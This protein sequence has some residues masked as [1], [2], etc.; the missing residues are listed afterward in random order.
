MNILMVTNT[1][2]PLLG[3]LEKS[4]EIFTGGYR[5]RGHR[6]IIV[7]PEFENSVTEEDLIR[8]PAIQ[9]FKGTDFSVQLPAPGVLSEALGSFRPDI[10]HAHHPFLLGDSA[11]RLSYK[12]NAPLVFTHHTLYEQNTHYVGDSEALKRFVAQLAT[13]YANLADCAFAPSDSVKDLM[14]ERGVDS[15]IEVV[16]TGIDVRRFTKGNPSAIR[17]KYGVPANAFVVGHLGRL[18]PEKNPEFMAQGVLR[19]LL[20]KPDAYFLVVGKGPSE[21]EI[22]TFFENAGVGDRLRFTGPLS[23]QELVDG[24]HAMDVFAF[25]SHSETQGLV[26]AEAMASGVP[27]VALDAPGAREVVWDKINGRLLY[28]NSEEE[29][30]L[31][32]EWIAALSGAALEK[33]RAACLSTAADFSKEKSIARALEIY[34]ELTAAKGFVRRTGENTPWENT[35]R[36]LQADWQLAKNLTR[37]TT[38]A[39]LPT[40]AE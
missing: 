32:L 12:Y 20:K 39:L 2:K 6:V 8:V 17:E 28:K 4:I 31:A 13:G 29:F 5:R 38:E 19:F 40:T 37:A 18:A 30:A 26:L 11:V 10:I 27:V 34:A 14:K 33:V 7:A 9:H 25:A 36:L 3:G 24:Y 22:K 21:D 16:P 35:V 23:G 1:Y 15:R